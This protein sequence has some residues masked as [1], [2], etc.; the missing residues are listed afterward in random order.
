MF[1]K[2]FLTLAA[3]GAFASPVSAELKAEDQTPTGKFT[4]AAE[5]KMILTATNPVGSQCDCTRGTI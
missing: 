2:I 3:V 1:H 4:T 5:V